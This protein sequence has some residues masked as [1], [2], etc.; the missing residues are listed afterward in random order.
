M[1]KDAIMVEVPI[2][3]T[4]I[5]PRRLHPLSYTLLSVCPQNTRLYKYKYKY[6]CKY[7]YKYRERDSHVAPFNV[8]IPNNF[9]L[10]PQQ[11]EEVQFKWGK[12][13]EVAAETLDAAAACS[14]KQ[15]AAQA[16]S[17]QV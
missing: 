15:F 10:F 7:K 14:K 16:R 2:T 13:F 12:R 9:Q 17:G 4:N 5:P 1:R 11:V 8:P 6:N 3:D